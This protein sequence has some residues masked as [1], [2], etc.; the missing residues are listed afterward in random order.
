MVN[1]FDDNASM[2]IYSRY[3][4]HVK[5]HF[6]SLTNIIKVIDDKINCI[7]CTDKKKRP[8]QQVEHV[9]FTKTLPPLV[10]VA[11]PV[12]PSHE[13]RQYGVFNNISKIF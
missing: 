7:D 9:P 8:V 5:G 13:A 2:M 3:V 11:W 4:L 1:T 6:H 10:T 12:D